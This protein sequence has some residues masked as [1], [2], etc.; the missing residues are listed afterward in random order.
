M[1]NPIH[2][3][4]TSSRIEVL[5][6]IRVH[7]KG[8]GLLVGLF[9]RRFHSV[10]CAVV[11]S[12]CQRSQRLAIDGFSQERRW[13]SA[14]AALKNRFVFDFPNFNFLCPIRKIQ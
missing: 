13:Y 9:R 5:S 3:G 8:L 10:E 2:S 14:A 6:P 7:G 12:T 1:F 11:H 4:W